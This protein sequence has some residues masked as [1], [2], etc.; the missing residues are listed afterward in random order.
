MR[1]KKNKAAE[2]KLRGGK[3]QVFTHLTR[4]TLQAIDQL[5]E[6][7]NRSRSNFI[8]TVLEREIRG[9]ASKWK[10]AAQ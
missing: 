4:A 7:D 8:E 6:A 3:V 10:R 2:A 5:A 1:G 9:R